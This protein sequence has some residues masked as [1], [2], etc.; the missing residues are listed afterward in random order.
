LLT[1]LAVIIGVT[2]GV[3]ALAGGVGFIGILFGLFKGDTA[4]PT[5][6]HGWLGI[7]SSALAAAIG[8][9][10]ASRASLHLRRPDAGTVRDMIGTAIF[11]IVI[12][13]VLPLGNKLHAPDYLLLAAIVGLYLLHRYLVKR[14]NARAFP[15]N[16]AAPTSTSAT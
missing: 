4:V 6:L 15:S 2:S 3:W 16:D 12:A 8:C 7:A 9:L 10:L 5:N 1:I 13:G 14:I 11:F